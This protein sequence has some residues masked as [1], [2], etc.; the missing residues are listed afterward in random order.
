[1]LSVSGHPKGIQWKNRA[2]SVE[3]TQRV[4]WNILRSQQH[5]KITTST[6]SVFA[7][8]HRFF[9]LAKYRC[10][11]EFNLIHVI[12]PACWTSPS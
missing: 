9:L 8:F 5:W 11:W 4:Q 7:I 10:F 1:M 12:V 6:H 3:G 2:Q